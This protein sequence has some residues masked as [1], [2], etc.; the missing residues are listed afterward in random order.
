MTLAGRGTMN[1]RNF[2]LG[3][4]TAATLSGAA[5]VTGASFANSVE[6]SST[7]FR[8]FVERQLA[9][10]GNYYDDTDLSFVSNSS[11]ID[12]S[13]IGQDDLSSLPVAHSDGSTDG[14]SNNL[15]VE[16][17]FDVSNESTADLVGVLEVENTGD[18]DETVGITFENADGSSDG[19]AA[20]VTDGP[21][22][23]SDVANAIQFT[24]GI[25]PISPDP[26][27]SAGTSLN[28]DGSGTQVPENGLTVGSGSTAE[29]DI[30]IAD[31]STVGSI[32]DDIA[33]NASATG[34]AFDGAVD[35]IELIDS[36]RV[37]TQ[38]DGG[39]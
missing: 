31:L 17:A 35:D 33:A 29:I 39:F 12:Y 20:P 38:P 14:G 32:Q 10:N 6:A 37:G 27:G 7:S 23:A 28:D 8:V 25:D 24:D 3:L 30:R 21:I 26:D 34:S 9:V 13:S 4:G 16:L 1:R 19:F 5:S 2:V 18:T 11:N 36:I 15:D 22:S